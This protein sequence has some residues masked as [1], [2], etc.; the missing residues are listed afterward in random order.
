MYS[1]DFVSIYE[2]YGWNDFALKIGKSL[3]SYFMQSKVTIQ[4]HLDLCS[5]TGVLCHFF[6]TKGLY[7]KGVDLSTSMIDLAKSKYEGID[8]VYHDVL[9][10]QDDKHYDLITCT[11]DSLNH[12]IHKGDLK[13]L[14]KNVFSLLKEEGYFVFDVVVK[15]AIQF[16]VPFFS[17]RSDQA[18]VKYLI[19][20]LGDSLIDL[21]IQVF[22]NDVMIFENH[23]KERIYSLDELKETLEESGFQIKLLDYKIGEEEQRVK[24][25]MYFIVRKKR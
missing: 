9:D 4:S 24:N 3:Y 5:G 1:R 2:Q 8:F 16:D 17:V 10:F 6:S 7:T 23:L 19:H 13:K 20:D 14:F 15:E 11:C 18:M 22:L 12:L 21:T 25:K